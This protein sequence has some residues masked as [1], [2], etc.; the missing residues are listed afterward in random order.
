[1]VHEDRIALITL[2]A[3]DRCCDSLEPYALLCGCL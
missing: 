3:L 1:M 2:P